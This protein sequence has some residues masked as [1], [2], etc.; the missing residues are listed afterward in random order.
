MLNR[1]LEAFLLSLLGTYGIILGDNV[2][3]W[4]P[5]EHEPSETEGCL[6]TNAHFPSFRS[7]CAFLDPLQ[8]LLDPLHEL[9]VGLKP[10]D[11]LIPPV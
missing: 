1:A 11:E 6:P 10:S 5:M 7:H 4:M 9:C 3:T 2:R 8:Q